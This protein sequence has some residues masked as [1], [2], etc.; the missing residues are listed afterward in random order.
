MKICI[1]VI[2]L[3][4]ATFWVMNARNNWD[5]DRSSA[6][7]SI[8]AALTQAAAGMAYIIPELL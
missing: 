1:G 3:L 7:W 6:W 8:A 4:G 2:W 5:Y